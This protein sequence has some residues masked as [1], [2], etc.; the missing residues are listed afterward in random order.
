MGEFSTYWGANATGTPPI[1]WGGL[2]Y[3][4]PDD[5]TPW[6]RCTIVHGDSDI[7]TLGAVGNRVWRTAG[8]VI[9]QV[10]TNVNL[11]RQP[12]DD[13]VETAIDAF[14]GKS[15][16]TDPAVRFRKITAKEVGADGP[17]FQQNVTIMFDYDE[18]A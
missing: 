2:P 16:G 1:T 8:A 10:F 11:S 17:W 14:R 13:L 6:T 3:D 4:P 15:V 5:L 9:V 7:V 12:S 18:T